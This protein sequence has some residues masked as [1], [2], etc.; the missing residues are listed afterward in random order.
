MSLNQKKSYEFST[1]E[2]ARIVCDYLSDQELL[3]D[4]KISVKE[5]KVL[6]FAREEL[7][8]LLIGLNAG[9][10]QNNKDIR[11][12]ENALRRVISGEYQGRTIDFSLGY[13]LG[14]KCP[15]EVELVK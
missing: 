14:A 1:N 6:L 15:Y 2:Q 7:S 5:N 11:E 3:Q 8:D 4:T 12:K 13:S 10:E 9:F